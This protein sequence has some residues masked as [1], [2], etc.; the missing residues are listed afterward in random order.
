MSLTADAVT[1]ILETR[2]DYLSARV[3][4]KKVAE[5]AGLSA[6]GPFDAAAA[7]KL[8]DALLAAGDH[9]EETAAALRAA[10]ADAGAEKKAPAQKAPAPAP[11]K[12]A[13]AKKGGDK[14]KK[15]K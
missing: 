7:G 3:V 4:L 2:Y 1:R 12:P 6:D 10:A 8:A 15:K 13:A 9:V 5:T 14:G 11:E